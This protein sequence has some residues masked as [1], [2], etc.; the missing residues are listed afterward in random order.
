VEALKIKEITGYR[1]PAST[2]QYDHLDLCF[3]SIEVDRFD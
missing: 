1:L 2:D 3:F